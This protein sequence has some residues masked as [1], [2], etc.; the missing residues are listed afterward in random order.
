VGSFGDRHVGGLGNSRELSADM[1]WGPILCE[2][3][4]NGLARPEPSGETSHV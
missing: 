1:G 2:E 4:R 3:S